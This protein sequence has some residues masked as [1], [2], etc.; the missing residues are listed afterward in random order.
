MDEGEV[1]LVREEV[2]DGGGDL[3]ADVVD[4]GQGCFGFCR[5]RFRGGDEGVDAAEL[6]GQG[7]GGAL[8]YVAD[9]EAEEDAV[10]GGFFGVFDLGEEGVGGLFADAFEG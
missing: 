7:L 4:A 9:A 8:A 2:A 10:E 6:V 1:A 5:G 3:G